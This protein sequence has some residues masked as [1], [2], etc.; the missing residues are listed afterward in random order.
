MLHEEPVHRV[1]DRPCSNAHECEFRPCESRA[2]RPTEQ[3][4]RHPLRAFPEVVEY[5]GS[6]DNPEICS[7]EEAVDRDPPCELERGR[8]T[9]RSRRGPDGASGSGPDMWIGTALMPCS[10]RTTSGWK[11]TQTSSASGSSRRAASVAL[12]SAASLPKLPA[13]NR[14]KNAITRAF[15]FGRWE[16][17]CLQKT[18]TL[19]P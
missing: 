13:P 1:P 14:P 5:S 10:D 16:V 6:R 9:I 8:C 11:Q 7:P 12:V 19:G 3:V 15:G 4:V 17:R 18:F 2:E